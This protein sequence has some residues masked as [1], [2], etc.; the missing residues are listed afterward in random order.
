MRNNWSLVEALDFVK[1]K[2]GIVRPNDGFIQQLGQFEV[3]ME[4]GRVKNGGG[5]GGYSFVAWD[6]ES[7]L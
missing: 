1:R 6:L 4:M 7:G 2:R 3:W 5:G